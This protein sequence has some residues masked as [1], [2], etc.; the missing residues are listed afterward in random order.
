MN[1][2]RVYAATS[3]APHG[4]QKRTAALAAWFVLWAVITA[5]WSFFYGLDVAGLIAQFSRNPNDYIGAHAWVLVVAV[6]LIGVWAAM[7]VVAAWLAIAGG[8]SADLLFVAVG[9][10][11]LTPL[12]AMMFGGILGFIIG[13]VADTSAAWH[14]VVGK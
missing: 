13:S 9:L 1:G 7:G 3:W 4:A 5:T 8:V 12:G 14:H 2:N 11:V 10:I 6:A